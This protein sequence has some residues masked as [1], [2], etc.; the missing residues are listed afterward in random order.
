MMPVSGMKMVIQDNKPGK[1]EVDIYD[2]KVW[3][4]NKWG[5]ADPKQDQILKVLLP[6]ASADERRK[7]AIDH[8]SKCLKRARKFTNAMSIISAPPEDV[9]LVLF[10]GDAVNTRRTA[11]VDPKTKQL[12]TIK[13]E[14]GDGKVLASSARFNLREGRPF[15]PYTIS[16]IKW[17]AV[18]HIQGAHMGIM[19]SYSFID[20]FVYYL[21]MFQS[22]K[23]KVPEQYLKM[24]LGNKKHK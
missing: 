20:N 9:M 18:L 5:L 12:K 11:T 4:A 16:P 8:L 10:C 2:P 13:W 7:I 1:P 22:P 14:A 15:V 23:R 19:D 24:V 17:Q 6:K 21:L 3:I